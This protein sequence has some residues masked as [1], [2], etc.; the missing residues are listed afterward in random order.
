METIDPMLAKSINDDVVWCGDDPINRSPPYH[1]YIYS[2]IT[3]KSMEMTQ[4]E[5]IARKRGRSKRPYQKWSYE[6]DLVILKK[7]KHLSNGELA[8]LLPARTKGAVQTRLGTLG[9]VRE[10]TSLI[11]EHYNLPDLCYLIG[12]AF[13]DAS[14]SIIPTSKQRHKAGFSLTSKDLEFVQAFKEKL[15]SV[16]KIKAPLREQLNKKYSKVY[17]NS[18]T[19]HREIVNF[20]LERR[21]I[22]WVQEQTEDCKREILRG[23]FDSDGS[24]SLYQRR[25]YYELL[26]RFGNKRF[27]DVF[28][29]L[30]K[31]FGITYYG[32]YERETIEF[33][34]WH[35]NAVEFYKILDYF[36]IK[37]KDKIMQRW[38]NAKFIPYSYKITPYQEFT[39]LR[40]VIEPEEEVK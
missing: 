31:Y 12:V 21:N 16:F 2:L 11:K 25:G 33:H 24:I 39:G 22:R 34:F 15:E 19:Q 4:V 30:I 27:P 20:L 26:I 37:R 13:G 8:I 36:T 35:S 14:L 10:K 1:F 6:E 17:F 7:F 9:L 32:K 23:M 5:G 38:L 28:E 29:Y 3:Y 18:Y 40:R